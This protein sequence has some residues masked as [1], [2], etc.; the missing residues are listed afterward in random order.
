MTITD[1][2]GGVQL[3]LSARGAGYAAIQQCLE[4][5]HEVAP[6]GPL[7][8]FFGV[9]PL[10]MNARSWYLGALGEIVVAEKLESLG[11]EWRVITAVPVGEG[12]A[13]IDHVVIGPSGVFTITMRAHA[14]RR[15]WAAG[16]ALRINGFKQHYVGSSKHAAARASKLL[17][18]AVGRPIVVTPLVV[19][20]GI[21]EMSYG[22]HRPEVD[23]VTSRGIVRNLKRRRTI[24]TPDAVAEIADVAGRRGTWHREAVVLDDSERLA[25]RFESLRRDVDLAARRSRMWLALGKLAV[26]AASLWLCIGLV[27]MIVAVLAGGM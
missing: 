25:Q 18:S 24:L 27:D 7:E 16:H 3:T 26:V 10:A 12:G 6:L 4:L 21:S 11:S 2:R 5:Q 23:T 13:D 1:I 20:V 17:T 15:V 14:N 8:K 22:L 9:N 19:L